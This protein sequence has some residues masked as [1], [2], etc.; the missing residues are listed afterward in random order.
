MKSTFTDDQDTKARRALRLL[1]VHAGLLGAIQTKGSLKGL[2]KFQLYMAML[3]LLDNGGIKARL[4]PS[5]APRARLTEAG[6]RP[7]LPKALGLCAPQ[8]HTAR[9]VLCAGLGNAELA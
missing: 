7:P 5:L 6:P 4:P 2:S 3:L 8:H 1:P 9:A